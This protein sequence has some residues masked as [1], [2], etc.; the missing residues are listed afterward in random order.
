MSV[1]RMVVKMRSP[2]DGLPHPRQPPQMKDTAGSSPRTQV[3]CPGGMSKTS[4]ARTSNSVPSSIRKRAAPEIPRRMWWNW[5]LTVPAAGP[6][7]IRDQIQQ[8]HQAMS[9]KQDS[10]NDPHHD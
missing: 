8:M 2:T 5:Q 3:S 1:M 9:Q 4:P 6:V 7:Y 10:R